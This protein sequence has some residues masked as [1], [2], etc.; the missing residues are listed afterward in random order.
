MILCIFTERMH[1]L[2]TQI[3]YKLD[4]ITKREGTKTSWEATVMATIQKFVSTSVSIE[5][6]SN[7]NFSIFFE[8]RIF[9]K[10][11]NEV[12]GFPNLCSS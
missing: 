2:R 5:S 10:N 12:S 8:I 1:L 6:S 4:D 9:W 7:F 3:G 11:S